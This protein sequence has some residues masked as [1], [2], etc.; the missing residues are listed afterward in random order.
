MHDIK[1]NFFL[2]S[3][4]MPSVNDSVLLV[5][6]VLDR[7][8]VAVVVV[9]LLGRG[10]PCVSPLRTLLVVLFGSWLPC[11]ASGLVVG[12]LLGDELLE[13]GLVAGEG[14]VLVHPEY[15][16]FNMGLAAVNVLHCVGLHVVLDSEGLG[17]F[18]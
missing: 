3:R 1:H 7:G 2:F 4:V 5:L 13:E 8:E 9:L 6:N 14:F 16:V 11:L 10:H 17:E 15:T 18:E 12:C